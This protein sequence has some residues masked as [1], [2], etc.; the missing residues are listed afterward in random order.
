MSRSGCRVGGGCH[1]MSSCWV[2]RWRRRWLEGT[3]KHQCSYRDSHC[4]SQ[5]T[6][7][8]NC[9]SSYARSDSSL[10]DTTKRPSGMASFYHQGPIVDAVTHGLQAYPGDPCRLLT[11]RSHRQSC[12]VHWPGN[13]LFLHVA[14]AGQTGS[15]RM[16]LVTQNDVTCE[17]PLNRQ[18]SRRS[19]IPRP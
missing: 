4:R 19:F 18:T 14:Y 10:E 17:I 15:G 16:A 13:F 12:Q 2:G 7:C 3:A 1:L 8:H 9:G 11:T 6:K 5:H